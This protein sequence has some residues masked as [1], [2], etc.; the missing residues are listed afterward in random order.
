[1]GNYVFGN[2]V[3]GTVF[4]ELFFVMAISGNLLMTF[5]LEGTYYRL[6]V[7]LKLSFLLVFSK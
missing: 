1:L 7:L 3:S 5:A 4:R 6:A 2:Y